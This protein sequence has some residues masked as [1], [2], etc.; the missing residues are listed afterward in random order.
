MLIFTVSLKES[1]KAPMFKSRLYSTSLG[2]IISPTNSAALE[3]LCGNTFA[4]LDSQRGQIRSE[5]TTT[6]EF[7]LDD[8]DVLNLKINTDIATWSE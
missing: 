2:A 4:A 3:S 8:D 5:Y 1:I 7:R 6:M